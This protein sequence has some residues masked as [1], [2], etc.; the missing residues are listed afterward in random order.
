MSNLRGKFVTVEGVDGAGK[1]TN[2]E[3]IY[4]LL[5]QAG[6]EVLLTR[7]PGGTKLGED[8]RNLILD[9]HEHNIDAVAELLLIFAA[10]AQHL[11]EVIEP[12]LSKGAWVLC[13]R[14]TDATFAYQGGGRGLSTAHI[15]TLETL[16]Q[17]SLR[18]DVTLLLDVDIDTG[19]ARS[20]RRNSGQPD[21]FEREQLAFKQ[22]VRDTY[23]SLAAQ[24]R[25]RVHVIDASLELPE[26]QR[27][28]RQI[29]QPYLQTYVDRSVE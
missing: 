6:L 24:H 26:V 18:P 27:Q 20:N 22:R 9:G 1:T 5:E 25:E 28:I 3:F 21:R 16:V 11:A 15:Q 2:I 8:L 17:D 10:R 7:E 13:D 14:F 4:Q 23:L 29:M 19:L 12:A